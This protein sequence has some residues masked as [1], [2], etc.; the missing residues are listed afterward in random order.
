MGS[1]PSPKM[2]VTARETSQKI[3]LKRTQLAMKRWQPDLEPGFFITDLSA[4]N[5]LYQAAKLFLKRPTLATQMALKLTLEEA[6]QPFYSGEYC[7]LGGTQGL[8]G[9]FFPESAWGATYQSRR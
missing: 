7:L 1:H 8:L 4:L 2:T 5:K 3:Y 6:E 9:D